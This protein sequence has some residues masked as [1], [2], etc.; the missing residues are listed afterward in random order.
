MGKKYAAAATAILTAILFIGGCSGSSF[1]ESYRK[2]P[3][4]ATS[5]GQGK[6][7]ATGGVALTGGT[8]VDIATPAATGYQGE[9]IEYARKVD[10]FRIASPFGVSPGEVTAKQ[11]PAQ[12][13][14]GQAPSINITPSGVAVSEG[15]ETQVKG[16]GGR[17]T[18]V[19]S[20]VTALKDW[21]FMA[22]IS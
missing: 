22:G 6:I 8:S 1:K 10:G 12:I 14:T 15:A 9:G 7:A 17:W 11:T 13:Q 20:V 4:A 18:W 5:T 19:D 16:G 2:T 3:A 21:G